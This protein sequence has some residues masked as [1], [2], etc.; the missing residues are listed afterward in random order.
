MFRK[1]LRERE[2]GPNSRELEMGIV[3]SLKMTT[4]L[5]SPSKD[6]DVVF[7]LFLS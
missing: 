5:I 2:L 1:T 7:R 6:R 3:S 4:L